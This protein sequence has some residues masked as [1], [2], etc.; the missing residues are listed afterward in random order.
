MCQTIFNFLRSRHTVFPSI[1]AWKSRCP[2]LTV[3]IFFSVVIYF[4]F[5]LK[6][7]KKTQPTLH[8]TYTFPCKFEDLKSMDHF[9][10]IFKICYMK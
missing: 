2:R 8:L 6:K 4:E 3:S 9:Q 7:K 5:K 10:N 1:G